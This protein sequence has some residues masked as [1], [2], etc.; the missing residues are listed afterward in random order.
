MVSRGKEHLSTLGRI[1]NMLG[2]IAWQRVASY[3]HTPM[4]PRYTPYIRILHP[5]TLLIALVASILE[6]FRSGWPGVKEGIEDTFGK[7]SDSVWWFAPKD[8]A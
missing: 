2:M 4:T 1:G 6:F 3:S 8:E 7:D 5:L